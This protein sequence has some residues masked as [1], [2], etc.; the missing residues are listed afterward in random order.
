[1]GSPPLM[2]GPHMADMGKIVGAGITPAY[3]GTT[4]KEF[5][6]YRLNRDHPRLCGDHIIGTTE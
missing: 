1:M 3:A 6:D 4:N 5:A 2:R